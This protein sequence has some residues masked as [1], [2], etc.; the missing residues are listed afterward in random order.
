MVVDAVAKK[1]LP[2]FIKLEDAMRAFSYWPWWLAVL[3]IGVGPALGEELM[4]RAFLGRG[5]LGRYGVTGGILLSS[6]F[7]GV[8]HLEPRQVAYA[9]VIGIYL[10]FVYWTTRSLWMPMLLHFLNNSLS[11]LAGSTDGRRLPLVHDLE[12]AAGNQPLILGIGALALLVVV[13]YALYQSRARVVVAADPASW[14]PA[15]PGV[16]HPPAG[17]GALMVHPGLSALSQSLVIGAAALFGAACYVGSFPM[18]Q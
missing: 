3:I 1:Y 14:Q 12:V 8:M 13:C 18:G 10:H 2:E 11:V 4:C 5:F 9:S 7:F 6:L 17:S 16:A 15:Y